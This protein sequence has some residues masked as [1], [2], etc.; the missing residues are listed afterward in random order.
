MTGMMWSSRETAVEQA[1]CGR[2]G[3]GC[4]LVCELLFCELRIFDL[5][6]SDCGVTQCYQGGRGA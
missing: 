1:E 6:T 5:R 3:E 2:V 4:L